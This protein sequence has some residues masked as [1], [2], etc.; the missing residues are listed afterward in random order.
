MCCTAKGAMTTVGKGI[1]VAAV[2]QAGLQVSVSTSMPEQAGQQH[3][4]NPKDGV[5]E[6]QVC[7]ARTRVPPRSWEVGTLWLPLHRLAWG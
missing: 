1:S 7:A 2:A 3:E 6:P 4:T 5:L